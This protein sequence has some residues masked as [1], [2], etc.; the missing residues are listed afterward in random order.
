MNKLQSVFLE[1]L[2]SALKGE[3]APRYADLS[4]EDW[5][6]LAKIASEQK[7]LPLF[8]DAVYTQ[9]PLQGLRV[10]VRHQVMLQTMKTE[11]FLRLYQMWNR[12]GVY[13]VVVK[14]IICRSLY[15]KPD[16]R[17]SSDE[18]VLVAPDQVSEAKNVLEAF[19]MSTTETRDD[20]YELPFRQNEGPLYIELHNHLFDPKS[21]SF[22]HWNSLFD[23]VHSRLLQQ[24]IHGTVIYTL[25]PTDH[26]LFL[27]C[28][29]LKH[30]IHSGFGLR[31]ICDIV[32]FANHFGAAVDWNE[33]IQ[34]CDSI[35]ASVFAA[36]IF[37]I[38]EKYFGFDKI[39]ACYPDAW[40]S[41]HID[42]ANMLND[43]FSSGIYG[44]SS[45]GRVHSSNIT[46]D[47]V[48]ASKNDKSTKP[49]VLGSIF[50][51]AS[52]LEGSYPYLQKY[53]VLL[54]VAWTQRIVRYA[55]DVQSG[56]TEGAVESIKI[57]NQRV[58]LLRQYGVIK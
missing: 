46:L 34:K 8:F 1:I 50:P 10:T 33:L 49:S 21:E 29:A 43:L 4:E 51:N 40:N 55:L 52:K 22:G 24:E 44:S 14:G 20:A 39:Q 38:G 37:Q 45:V 26:L 25:S 42:D 6:A 58:D 7:L 27:V 15:Q 31:Q 19:G 48:A 35:S 2:G 32:T 28:H 56:K 41:L 16:H 17:P 12:A 13:P 30:F 57:G 9:A 18:D 47:A 36:T 11:E 53:P 3:S 54:P 23:G 5:L